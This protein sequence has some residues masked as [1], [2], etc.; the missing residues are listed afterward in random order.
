MRARSVLATG[1]LVSLVAI[2]VP[3]ATPVLAFPGANGKIVFSSYRDGN[4][5]DLYVMNADGT[6]QVALTHNGVTDSGAF[7]QTSVGA[8]A[9]ARPSALRRL[10]FECNLL[11]Q[12]GVARK[13]GAAGRESTGARLP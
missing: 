2:V 9:D 4:D 3:V 13:I 11:Q 6:D 12:F 5:Y 10:C 7:R 1:A 8:G